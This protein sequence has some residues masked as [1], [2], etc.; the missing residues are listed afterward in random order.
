[1]TDTFKIE[2]T[3]ADI[4]A[5]LTGT[6]TLSTRSK[7]A[8]LSDTYTLPS[9][10]L[11]SCG[12]TDTFT[13]SA[14]PSSTLYDAVTADQFHADELT[15]RRLWFDRQRLVEQLR[16][17]TQRIE[18]MV[19]KTHKSQVRLQLHN[20]TIIAAMHKTQRLT[21]ERLC[22]VT[23][24]LDR[25]LA[26]DDAMADNIEL[27]ASRVAI[28]HIEMGDALETVTALRCGLETMGSVWKRFAANRVGWMPDEWQMNEYLALER[29]ATLVLHVH[30]WRVMRMVQIDREKNHKL[31][32][33]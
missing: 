1:M 3:L 11:R 21:E 10:A 2:E 29:A 13:I 26:V 19:T 24:A 30:L 15:I 25:I 23:V 14:S 18:K 6:F 4:P 28:E 27:L 33:K 17:D 5:A 9:I 7:F 8:A 22:K 12:L 20:R 31:N 16:C 32:L